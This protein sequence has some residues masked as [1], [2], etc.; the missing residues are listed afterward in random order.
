MVA[1]S[2]SVCCAQPCTAQHST[3]QHDG[4]Q[5]TAAG[6]GYIAVAH[7]TAQHKSETVAS[8]FLGVPR[9]SVLLSSAALLD[10]V[11]WLYGTLCAVPN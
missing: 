10:F 3:A 5:F 2:N 7:S 11:W 8:V 9:C 6:H 1:V 4:L